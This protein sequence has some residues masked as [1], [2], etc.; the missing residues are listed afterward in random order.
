MRLDPLIKELDMMKI[1]LNHLLD[2][3]VIPAH[4]HG[5]Q[6]CQ[7]PVDL[8]SFGEPCPMLGSYLS[9]EYHCK[10]GQICPFIFPLYESTKLWDMCS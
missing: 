10:H 7:V 8:S 6:A 4:C 9:I 3:C 5:L 1:E 2:L